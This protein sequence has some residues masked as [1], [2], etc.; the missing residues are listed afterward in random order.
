MI[1]LWNCLN[2]EMSQK[3]PD[4]PPRTQV[5]D[6]KEQ[7]IDLL[8]KAYRTAYKNAYGKAAFSPYTHMTQHLKANQLRV[9]YD[10]SKYSCQGQEHYGKIMKTLVKTQ[11]NF[12]L[13][14]KKQKKD[15]N[16]NEEYEKCYVQQ[17]VEAI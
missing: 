14:G 5:R 11:T 15:S 17:S 1:G 3:D 4:L 8:A 10:L 2:T 13:G 12:R 7:E 16:G 6:L 9:R